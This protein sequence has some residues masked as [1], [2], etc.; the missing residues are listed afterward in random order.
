MR[1]PS[2]G[3]PVESNAA[4]LR[5]PRPRS[6]TTLL[7]RLWPW[8]NNLLRHATVMFR[9][10]IHPSVTR[11]RRDSRVGGR[12]KLN[13]PKVSGTG[14]LKCSGGCSGVV[15]GDVTV[16]VIVVVVE[17][18]E[19]VSVGITVRAWIFGVGGV[20][21]GGIEA[22][23]AFHLSGG[24]RK[25]VVVGGGIGVEVEIQHCERKRESGVRVC[26]DSVKKSLEGKVK[27]VS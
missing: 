25:S 1:F 21:D 16:S 3:S 6:P 17:Y 20:D 10:H 4:I 11:G 18:G 27:G 2:S 15:D 8:S 12:K 22:A 26:Y 19:A 24:E 23:G 13:G 7:H 9:R 14:E 5:A